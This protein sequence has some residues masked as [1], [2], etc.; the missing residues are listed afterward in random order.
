MALT[1]RQK[2]LIVEKL[3]SVSRNGCPIC[4]NRNWT[5]ADEIV[6][7]TT[8]SLGGSTVIGG[9]F[10]PMAQVICANCGFVAHH[11]VGALGVNLSD[12]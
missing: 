9:P 10:I 5:I 3:T 11:A 12:D 6:M 2:N 8:V 4:Q 7:A 1:T